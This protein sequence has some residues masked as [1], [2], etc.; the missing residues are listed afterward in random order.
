M[1]NILCSNHQLTKR[2][3]A[4]ND[5][6]KGTIHGLDNLVH[7]SPNCLGSVMVSALP[8]SVEGCGFD[9]QQGQTKGIKICI[10]C[11]SAKHAAERSKSKDWFNQS[12]HTE[13]E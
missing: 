7:R 5:K 2:K 3:H 9:P 1:I 4:H 11:F 12:Q 13:S 8:L 6:H 10:C